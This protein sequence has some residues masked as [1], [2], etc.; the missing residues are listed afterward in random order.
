MIIE[1]HPYDV[2]QNNVG[3]ANKL[4]V[5]IS[6][7]HYCNS[8]GYKLKVNWD[9]FYDLFPNILNTNLFTNTDGDVKYGPPLY[10]PLGQCNNCIGGCQCSHDVDYYSSTF[11][12][13]YYFNM[14]VPKES[15]TNAVNSIGDNIKDYFGVHLRLTDWIN[16]SHQ[17]K[18]YLPSLEDY[19]KRIDI[20]LETNRGFYFTSD[21][22]ETY[23][24]IKNRYSSKVL[25][26]ENKILNRTDPKNFDFAYIDMKILS[27]TKF[28]I[29]NSESTFSFHAARISKIP[30]H[31]YNGH[32]W[33]IKPFI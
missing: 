27:K 19:I 2:N 20:L 3:L 29:G 16:Y 25:C 22:I 7:A 11:P 14:L 9:Y 33:E 30:L 26:L 10:Y 6:F 1:I 5:I 8:L 24:K 32:S 23:S 13:E 15:I 28:I 17:N 18:L 12:F 21:E 31:V 4:R